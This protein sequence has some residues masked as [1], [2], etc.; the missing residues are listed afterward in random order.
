M[1][2]TWTSSVFRAFSSETGRNTP[3]GL[4]SS[5]EKTVELLELEYTKGSLSWSADN[6]SLRCC[7]SQCECF[8]NVALT[9]KKK[10]LIG[11]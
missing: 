10:C 4:T 5:S 1:L 6:F 11:K 3:G 2:V 9:D 8:N 7:V